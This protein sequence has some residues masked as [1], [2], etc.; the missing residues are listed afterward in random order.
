[1]KIERGRFKRGA[2]M[3]ESLEIINKP[4]PVEFL[5][6]RDFQQL[7]QQ[8]EDLENDQRKSKRNIST[9]VCVLYI[10]L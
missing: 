3:R 2:T 9:T 4:M 1:M 6:L 8:S 5:A 7:Q 10:F